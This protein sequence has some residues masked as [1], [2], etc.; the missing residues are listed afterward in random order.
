MKLRRRLTV[1]IVAVVAVALVV[2][3][4]VSLLLVSASER[5]RSERDI[6]RE[7][8]ELALGIERVQGQAALQQLSRFLKLKELQLV[9]LRPDGGVVGTLPA[10]VTSADIQPKRLLDGQSIH[11]RKGNTVFAAAP[12]RTTRAGAVILTRRVG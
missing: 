3:G 2:S 1:S 6:T 8:G 5:R 7:A 9:Q 10:G 4:L 11:G 12:V